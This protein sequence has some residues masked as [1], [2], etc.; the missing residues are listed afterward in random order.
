MEQENLENTNQ[1]NVEDQTFKDREQIFRSFGERLQAWQDSWYGEE[2]QPAGTGVNAR[3]KAKDGL[4]MHTFIARG[5]KTKFVSIT[6]GLPG[7]S[8]MN[9]SMY[10]HPSLQRVFA[11]NEVDRTIVRYVE[12]SG[13]AMGGGGEPVSKWIW[14]ANT[15]VMEVGEGAE[16]N[17]RR[18]S[19]IY[20]RRF[21]GPLIE[22]R[23]KRTLDE[24]SK[25]ISRLEECE[26]TKSDTYK[27][28][29]H[30]AKIFENEDL[31]MEPNK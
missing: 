16:W 25:E 6:H 17:G 4:P 1:S 19:E 15:G 22:D 9:T 2:A 8:N 10:G 28:Y 24:F 31:E 21:S 26:V 5:K 29:P 20:L 23:V 18:Y 3:I 11:Y 12:T 27:L 14:H 7:G 13:G 30:Q